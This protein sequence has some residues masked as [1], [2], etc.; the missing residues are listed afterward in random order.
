MKNPDVVII[1]L[2]WNGCEDTR[3]CLES[4]YAVRNITFHVVVVDNGS[5]DGSIVRLRRQFADLEIIELATN[6]GYAAG[7]NMGLRRAMEYNPRAVLLLNN[8]TILSPE[9]P[10]RLYSC[11]MRDEK[12]A[13]AVPKIYYAHAKKMIWY[14]GG[15]INWLRVSVHQDGYRLMDAGQFDREKEVQFATGCALMVKTAWFRKYGGLDESFYSYYEDM[16]LSLRIRQSGHKLIYCPAAVLWHRVGAGAK[17]EDYSPYYL[18]YQ[19][20]NRLR[21]F[22]R[23]RSWFYVLYAFLFGSIVYFKIRVLQI[24]FTSGKNKRLRLRAVFS[25]YWDSLRGRTG[26]NKRWESE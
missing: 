12:V 14:A 5:K 20:R 10:G 8:D 19:T 11:L 3:A 23:Y 15:S 21:A 18:Y 9:C 6:T 7:N 13:A 25:G 4:V 24:L 1:I 2:N 16:D 22:S 26:A 17:A